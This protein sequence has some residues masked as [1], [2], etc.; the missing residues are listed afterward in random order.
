[1]RF[2]HIA[3][4]L[5]CLFA[6]GCVSV[7][8]DYTRPDSPEPGLKGVA[9]AKQQKQVEA[10]L[11]KEK[12]AD[13]WR[14]FEDPVMSQ[15]IQEALKGNLDLRQA[16]ARVREARARMTISRAGLF[17]SLDSSALMQKSRKISTA[18]P[19][20]EG[21]FTESDYYS[22]GF[23][24]S[25]EID[26]FGGTRRAVEAAQADIQAQQAALQSVWVSLAGEV[27]QTYVSIRSYQQRIK[28]ALGN[29]RVQTETLEI[30]ESRLKAGLS[31]ELHVQQAR[32][33]LESTRSAIPALKSGLERAF[34]TLAVLL[35][36]MP[37]ELQDRLK[38]SSPIPTA[39]FNVV[40]KIPAGT[41]RQRPDILL[42]ERNLAAQT[43]RIGEATAKLYPKFHLIGSIGL[44]SLKAENLLSTDNRAWSILP[45]IDWPIFH[46][47]SIRANIKMQSAKQEQML[48]QYEKAV[49]QAAKEIR[50]ALISFNQEHDRMAALGAA[51]EAAQAAM[52][53]AAQK[54]RHGL[55]N[56]TDVLDAQRSLFAYDDNRIRSQEAI[57]SNL[58]SLYKA[59]GGGWKP[60]QD[61]SE[62][63]APDKEPKKGQAAKKNSI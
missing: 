24:A 7:G 18:T 63:G 2:K 21:V 49:L 12:L 13:W 35:G 6:A 42:V 3:I 61:T 32:Y 14:V 40:L 46:A 20:G 19:Q 52:E 60:M 33:N 5:L 16:R 9:D 29:L 4:P 57:T 37:G 58:I 26:I 41:L 38:K 53:I 10:N 1:M 31:D 51:V 55:L 59:L 25:W 11:T 8:P 15:L 28:V 39:P 56:F 43:A 27:A 44:E 30:L 47:G 17:P 34:N 22:A 36:K 48:A 62:A 50:D 23:D 54:Y 45:R